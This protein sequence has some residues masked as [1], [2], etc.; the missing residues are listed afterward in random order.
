MRYTPYGPCARTV[1]YNV[2]NG[3]TLVI[4][5]HRAVRG[6]A[7]STVRADAPTIRPADARL[8]DAGRGYVGS[9]CRLTDEYLAR[10]ENALALRETRTNTQRVT[11]HTQ[12]IAK[13]AGM[14]MASTPT[15]GGIASPDK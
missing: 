10:R 3:R 6:T 14:N 8:D 1:T 2:G 5:P 12:S 9:F 13:V 7:T 15:R 11:R 4:A